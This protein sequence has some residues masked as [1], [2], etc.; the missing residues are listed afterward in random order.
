MVVDFEIVENEVGDVKIIKVI[1]ELDALVSPKF[2]EKLS[3]AVE[4]GS[5]KIIIDFE[6]L[7]HIN[8]LA[9]GILRS[10]LKVLEKK[11]GEIKIVQLNDHIKEIFEM[12]GLDEIIDIYETEEDAIEAFKK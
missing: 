11:G 8:S 7:I 2:K 10:Q 1:G 9:M 12:I 6:N 4:T 3:K 5:K